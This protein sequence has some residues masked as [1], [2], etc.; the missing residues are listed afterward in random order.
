VGKIQVLRNQVDEVNEKILCLLNVR[1]ILIK[2]IRELKDKVSSDYFDPQREEEMLR[3]IVEKNDGPLSSKMIGDIFNHIFK[4]NLEFMGISHEKLPLVSDIN[5]VK[6]CTIKEMFNLEKEGPYI[7]AGP[8][9]IEN[10]E[11]V[12]KIAQILKGNNIKFI[13]GGAYKPRTSPYDFQGLGKEGVKILSQVGK[14]HNLIT[15]SEVVDGGEVE[16]VAKHIDVIQIGARNM[17]NFELLKRAGASGKPI[18]LKRGMSATIKEFIFAAEYIALQGNKKI[19][20]CERGIRTFENKTRNTLDISS[21]PIIK[22]ETQL[23]IIVD[24]SHSLGRKDIIQPIA[25]AALAVGA[26]GLMVEV[27]PKPE[28]ALS[29]S[30]QQLDPKEF[31]ELLDVLKVK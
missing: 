21:I 8:C 23:P 5:K 26:D 16:S 18:L 29:D 27:H 9:A 31:E 20:L 1:A 12:E 30:R 11:Y 28:L 10:L 13:R 14:K 3:K 4:V 2:Q 19:I 22:K 6:F 15:V 24:I 25:K 7:I 17:Q